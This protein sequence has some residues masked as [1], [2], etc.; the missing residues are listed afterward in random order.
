MKVAIVE[1]LDAHASDDFQSDLEVLDNHKARRV[2]SAGFVYKHDAIGITLVRDIDD[3][4][5]VDGRIF[6]PAGMI[7]KVRTICGKA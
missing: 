6:I 1:W 2:T 5:E 7:K 4:D 3:V